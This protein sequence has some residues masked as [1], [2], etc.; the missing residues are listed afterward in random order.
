MFG[1]HS[2][3]AVIEVSP[4]RIELAVVRGRKV[5]AAAW[6]RVDDP[7]FEANWPRS[8]GAHE[9]TLAELVDELNCRGCRAVVLLH[10]P[11]CASTICPCP[12]NFG[13][14]EAESA[15]MLAVGAVAD[16][17]IDGEPSNAR[18]VH[19]DA[20]TSGQKAPRNAHF[21]AAAQR[22]ADADAAVAFVER[23]GLVF[24]ARRSGPW[25][26][27]PR[28]RVRRHWAGAPATV[29]RS[30][31]SASTARPSPRSSMAR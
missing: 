15:A 11:G 5:V 20:A 19:T 26:C 25:P 21:L 12:T 4:S 28:S 9:R 2:G 10:A 23:A 1:A 22:A 16:F 24:A 30:C 3:Y 6:R 14:P 17:P 29:P 7:D 13:E 18:A 31:G 8:L 27:W